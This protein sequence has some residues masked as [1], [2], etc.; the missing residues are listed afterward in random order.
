MALLPRLS[1]P[2]IPQH[3]IQ[4]GNN[5]S[6]SFFA[7]DDYRCYLDCLHDAAERHDVAVHAYV[8]MT[9][10]VHLLLTPTDETGI[11]RAIQ[12]LGR[13]YVCYIKRIYR[14]SGTLWE[15]RY[16]ASLVDNDRYLL[17]CYCYFELN[18]VR[19]QMVGQPAGYPWSSYR[20]NAQGRSDP[21]LTPHT[22]YRR[23]GWTP[24]E[25]QQAY[26]ALF[27]AHIGPDALKALRETVNSNRGYGSE[28]SKDQVEVAL[29]RRVRPSKGGRLTNKEKNQ[30][31]LQQET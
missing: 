28:R 20:T 11:A 26:L 19:A 3:V 24:A 6:A 18:P 7:E 25:R 10:H 29:K 30:D 8:L 2:D 22:D 21:L 9:N 17:T 14:R 1:L 5:R 16:Q 4:R 27:Q 23:L 15:G 13:R 12:T 31:V